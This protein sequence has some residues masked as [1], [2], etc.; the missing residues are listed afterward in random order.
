MTVSRHIRYTPEEKRTAVL[1][2]LEKG[3][4]IADIALDLRVGC[5]TVRVWVKRFLEQEDKLLCRKERDTA[6]KKRSNGG[7]N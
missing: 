5:P 6:G 1:R 4:E 3:E 7:S 2:Y